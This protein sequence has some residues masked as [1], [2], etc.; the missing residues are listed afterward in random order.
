MT[1]LPHVQKA[2]ELVVL[3]EYDASLAALEGDPDRGI[4]AARA[5]LVIARSIGEEPFLIS[6]LVRIACARIAVQS[7]IQVLAWGQPTEGLAELQAELRN[8]AD[9]PWLLS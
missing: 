7:A 8:E 5:G 1:L 2:R 6:Q 9:L 3:L 4:R